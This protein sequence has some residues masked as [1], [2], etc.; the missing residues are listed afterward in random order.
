VKLQAVL[1]R[2]LVTTGD[3]VVAIDHRQGLEQLAARVGKTIVDV[4][5]LPACVSQAMREF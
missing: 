4:D 5:K 1:R 2:E 3:R